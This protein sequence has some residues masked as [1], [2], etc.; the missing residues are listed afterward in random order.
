MPEIELA[1][2]CVRCVV[3]YWSHTGVTARMST[4]MGDSAIGSE[5]MQDTKQQFEIATRQQGPEF[6]LI[7]VK[8]NG[9]AW[10]FKRAQR[11]GAGRTVEWADI[12]RRKNRLFDYEQSSCLG[13]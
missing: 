12:S 9:C 8:L 6:W 7:P 3:Q 4:A 11:D 1:H 5:I 10:A 13:L 2:E